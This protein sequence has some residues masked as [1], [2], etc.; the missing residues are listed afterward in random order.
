MITIII[1]AWG[2]LYQVG[3]NRKLHRKSVSITLLNDGRHDSNWLDAQQFIF[4]KISNDP[5]YDWADF[6]E[7]KFTAGITGVKLGVDD[8]KISESVR[9]VLNQYEFLSIAIL[10]ETAN[11]AIIRAEQEGVF[12]MIYDHLKEYIRVAREKNNDDF[13]YINFQTVVERWKKKPV[14]VGPID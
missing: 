2:V 14:P 10:S 9:I 3:K 8:E 12:I 7:R 4:R 5:K 11:G 1:T 13:I 6:A